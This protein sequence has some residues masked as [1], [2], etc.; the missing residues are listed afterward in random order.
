M[1]VTG[2]ALPHIWGVGD[3]G[4]VTDCGSILGGG[5]VL[6]LFCSTILACV[7]VVSSL[8][9]DM[10]WPWYIYASFIT[11]L[12]FSVPKGKIFGDG[13]I[14]PVHGSSIFPHGWLHQWRKFLAL[15]CSQEIII[16][17]L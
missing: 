5:W 3:D 7:S 15:W 2:L 14:F 6:F 12:I 16:L 8:V 17:C 9:F 11:A 4:I 13:A 10:I 1:G